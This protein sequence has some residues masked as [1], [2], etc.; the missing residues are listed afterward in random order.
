M[1]KCENGDSVRHS[2]WRDRGAS[3]RVVMLWVIMAGLLGGDPCLAL[4]SKSGLVPAEKCAC[5]P[6]PEAFQYETYGIYQ[7]TEELKVNLQGWSRVG[8]AEGL[9]PDDRGYIR[10]LGHEKRE[11][12]AAIQ[13]Y[14]T[15]VDLL[16]DL[17][18][19]DGEGKCW[20]ADDSAYSVYNLTQELGRVVSEVGADG[21]LLKIK[22]EWAGAFDP[23]P[24]GACAD[25][26]PERSEI[27]RQGR[28]VQNLVHSLKHLAP[29]AHGG[30]EVSLLV[31][32]GGAGSRL[33]DGAL[34]RLHLGVD[35][36]LIQLDGSPDSSCPWEMALF[37]RSCALAL[38]P[39]RATR[40]IPVLKSQCLGPEKE[41]PVTLFR[42]AL[43][44]GFKGLALEISPDT[45]TAFLTHN[46]NLLRDQDDY[47]A[48]LVWRNGLADALCWQR[49]NL[50]LVLGGA[51][52]LVLLVMV[53]A[54]FS[55]PARQFL[56]RYPRLCIGAVGLLGGGIWLLEAVEPSMNN[57]TNETIV[58]IL[59]LTIVLLVL[60]W[61]RER[62]KS[63][64]P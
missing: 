25:S 55:C 7:G 8:L 11:A 32:A 22:M 33:D 29:F 30:R 61:L 36:V 14:G 13:T 52:G 4:D 1:I 60:V 45:A 58:A 63:R 43:D 3:L 10:T 20:A 16:V 31:M 18:G 40:V 9:A 57:W 26:G 12:V 49:E 46:Q 39:P 48:G 51:A 47:F 21:V 6:D 56:G 17:M 50:K 5:P 19:T 41:V 42:I 37:N 28:R 23:C 59:A 35:R 54:V 15:R 2:R 27:S 44:L 24:D 62:Q 53:V 38:M 34:E 64:F